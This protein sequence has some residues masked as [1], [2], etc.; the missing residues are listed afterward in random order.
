MS[1]SASSYPF[2]HVLTFTWYFSSHPD[3][4]PLRHT[5]G[6][7]DISIV[8]DT[9]AAYLNDAVDQSMILGEIIGTSLQDESL[10]ERFN[11]TPPKRLKLSR[12]KSLYEKEDETAPNLLSTRHTIHI[13]DEFRLPLGSG[14]VI[15]NTDESMID[16]HLT[17][18]NCMGFSPLLPNAPSSHRFSFDMDLKRPY[19]SFKG[20]HA[21]LGFD[22]A[23]SMLSVGHCQNEDVFLA[24]APNEFLRG[25]TEPTAPGHSTASPLMSKRHYRQMVMMMVH[26][27]ALLPERAF[28]N[29]CSVY[30][31]DLDSS[32]P[33]F[34]LITDAL[35]VFRF[36]PTVPSFPSSFYSSPFSMST[37]ARHTRAYRIPSPLYALFS[38]GGHF[39]PDFS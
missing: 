3:L 9:L 34:H 16:Y 1:L 4:N 27:L 20:K 14:R 6:P 15:V 32:K 39:H 7:T 2:L 36:M 31:Q 21:M 5:K 11:K 25:R 37:Y 18:A 38:Y 10:E 30:E 33:D 29:I 28:L 22:P 35:Y 12:L 24:M 8:P 17:V 23:G 13:D 26:F 19:F